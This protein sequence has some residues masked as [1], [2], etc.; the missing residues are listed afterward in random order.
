MLN[1]H[2]EVDEDFAN[3]LALIKV[4]F[5]MHVGG[6]YAKICLVQTER[7]VLV[8][9]VVQKAA[10]IHGAS[11]RTFEPFDFQFDCSNNFSC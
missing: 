8:G 7:V 2:E 3:G 4:R 11:L 10:A 5:G 1:V 6:C 9:N